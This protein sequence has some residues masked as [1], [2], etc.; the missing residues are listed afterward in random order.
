ME[1]RVDVNENDIVRV[2]L[3]DT[4]IIDV[5]A[6]ASTNKEFKGVVTLIANTAKDKVSADAIT[7]FE[8]RILILD[9][10]YQDLVKAGNRFPFRPGMT[11]S[12]DIITTRKENV[13]SVPLAAVTTRNPNQPGEG[14]GGPPNRNASQNQN[15]ANQPPKAAEPKTVIFVNDNGTAKMTEV[16]TGI[17]DYD[18]I[19]ILSD[20]SD[21]TEVVTGPYI[22]VSTR[23]KEGDK[24][25][26]AEAPKPDEGK[27]D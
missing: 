12:A 23:L 26:P 27:K 10:S 9:S 6:Y 5:D 13:L 1:V 3:G 11:A 4:A 14:Q 21:S 16:K 25:R 17:S 2:A 15:S 18:N 8:V 22:V 24:I 20:I 19:E 7:E